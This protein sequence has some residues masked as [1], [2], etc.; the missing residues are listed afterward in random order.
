M[1]RPVYRHWV[2]VQRRFPAAY[3]SVGL[4]VLQL[5]GG[6][7]LPG[8]QTAQWIHALVVG[9]AHLFFLVQVYYLSLGLLAPW[10]VLLALHRVPGSPATLDILRAVQYALLVVLWQGTGPRTIALSAR[11]QRT[12]TLRFAALVVSHMASDAAC[13]PGSWSAGLVAVLAPLDVAIALLAWCLVRF[14]PV[15]ETPYHALHRACN[16][17][18]PQGTGASACL[19]LGD[20]SRDLYY[21]V[22]KPRPIN[23]RIRH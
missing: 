4:Q 16:P 17:S 6:W 7:P 9:A 1:D 22:R 18:A 14:W 12:A 5:A 15:G 13:E 11:A 3:R 19:G 20:M 10:L 23:I 21:M 8:C 2:Q